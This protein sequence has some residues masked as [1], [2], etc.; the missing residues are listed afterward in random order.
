MDS[1]VAVASTAQIPE[2]DDE[3]EDLSALAPA[4]ENRSGRTL[5][6]EP[7]RRLVGLAIVMLAVAASI[8]VTTA[9]R[10][11]GLS[12]F[13]EAT[14]ADYAYQVVH[15]HIP[16]KGSTFAPEIRREVACHQF[17]KPVRG[18]PPCSA[19]APPN[20]GFPA[21]GQNYNYIHPPVYYL[22]TG[23]L[24]QA[25]DTLVGGGHFIT[26]ARLVG[27]LWM[28]AGMLVLYL[29]LR[30]FG[31]RWPIAASGGV[32]LAC[33]PA[34]F[35]LEAT[36]T[37]DAAAPLAGGLAL[38]AIS[39]IVIDKNTNW[40]MPS[41]FAF[42]VAGTKIL[43]ALPFLLIGLALLVIG[44]RN[45]RADPPLLRRY[46]ILAAG[47]LAAVLVVYLGWSAFQSGRGVPHWHNP[48]LGITT[49]PIPGSPVNA[50]LTSLFSDSNM[51][52]GAYL[53]K[54]LGNEA[55]TIWVRLLAPLTIAGAAILLGV[56]RTWSARWLVGLVALVGLFTFP[57]AVE[58]HVFISLH[59]YMPH[60]VPRYGISFAA[61][62]IGSLAIAAEHR[63]LTKTTVGFTAA[64][65]V[66]VMS[67]LLSVG[68]P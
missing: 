12:P 23:A 61:M 13:D 44:L 48:V 35:Y 7:V 18:L 55:L 28:F 26:M 63:R 6:G 65:F 64:S 40:L 59:L 45:R 67:A 49:K 30:R 50:L 17:A 68:S 34:V 62:L 11:P 2:V 43:N 20:K 37:N 25:G 9:L 19:T 31:V 66:I 4:T 5:W 47:M 8:V 27:V 53:P 1:P 58:L 39:R 29:A 32:L 60:V 42:L 10:S 3:P 21:G 56:A 51:M 52:S 57:L 46:L 33:C 38:L 36:I 22:I 15:G 41:L 24:A 16:A 14:H 54:P